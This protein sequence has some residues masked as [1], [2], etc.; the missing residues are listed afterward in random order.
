MLLVKA[1]YSIGTY[2]QRD[3]ND[4]D[5]DV[6]DLFKLQLKKITFSASQANF[7]HYF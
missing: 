7:C 2:F 3:H 6:E 1:T 5:D 4:D